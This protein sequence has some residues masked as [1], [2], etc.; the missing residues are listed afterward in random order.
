MEEILKNITETM[1]NYPVK[2][3]RWLPTDNIIVGMVEDPIWGKPTLHEG[4]VTCKWR[5][6]GRCRI[7][8]YI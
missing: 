3:L 1:G 2:D 6:N 8:M 7:Y 4:Y 5:S